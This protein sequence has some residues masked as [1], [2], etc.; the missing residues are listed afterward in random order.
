MYRKSR[1]KRKKTKRESVEQRKK[2]LHSVH[3]QAGVEKRYAVGICIMNLTIRSVHLCIIIATPI[4][5]CIAA[6]Y[7]SSRW[8]MSVSASLTLTVVQV[9]YR[10]KKAGAYGGYEIVSEDATSDHTREQLLDI[11]CGKKADRNC[12]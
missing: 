6:A 8:Y 12:Y 2:T 1:K 3:T 5:V 4:A 7:P 9:V 11:R 10:V